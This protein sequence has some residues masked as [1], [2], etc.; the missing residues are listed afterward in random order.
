KTS[1]LRRTLDPKRLHATRVRAEVERGI[2]EFFLDRDFLETRTPLLVPCPGM[3]IHIRPFEVKQGGFLPTSPEF[4]MKRLLVGGL[5]KIF[6]ICPSFRLEPNSA[7]HH[8]EF[9]ML[10]WYR[11]YAGLEE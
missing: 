4:A 2:R 11:A 8:P 1:W 9:T 10:E 3:E 7:T 6:Q 5:E